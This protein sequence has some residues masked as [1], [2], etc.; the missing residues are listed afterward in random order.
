MKKA[1][2]LYVLLLAMAASF[3]VPRPV[4]AH[5]SLIE[6]VPAED[7]RLAG[8]PA[9]VTLTFS[10]RVEN[11]LFS[12]RVLDRRGKAISQ[13]K[14]TISNNGR[15][16]SL[17]LPDAGAG[18]YT[19]SY[20]VISADG[21][22][23]SGA[24]VYTVGQP[25]PGGGGT[26]PIPD[27]GGNSAR[28]SRDMSV[29]D[30]LAF[31]SRIAYYASLIGLAGWV[32]WRAWR[33]SQPEDEAART[34]DAWS[35]ALKRMF[36]LALIAA[37]GLQ[38]KNYVPQPNADNVLALFFH[39]SVGLSWT[40]SL[41]LALA[42]FPLLHRNRWIDSLW[43]GLLLGAK[44]ASGHAYGLAS[45]RTALALDFVH[46]A[47]AAIW[48][49]GLLHLVAH[50][51]RPAWIAAFLPAFSFAALCS[52]LIL[53][54]SGAFLTLA[55]VPNVAYVLYTQWGTVLLIKIALVV[56]VAAIG[57][58]IRIALKKQASTAFARLV[59][60]DFALMTAV[61]SIV[62]VLTFLNPQPANE[63]L[64]WH[65]MGTKQH[66]SAVIKP[67][68]PGPNT[69][70]VHVWMPEQS[71]APKRVELLL[72]RTSGGD[73]APVEVPLEPL[74]IDDA[75]KSLYAGFTMYSYGAQGAQLSL[76]GKWNVQVRVMDANDDE[77]VYDKEMRIY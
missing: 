47:A 16:L 13:A 65:V 53:A 71:A 55:F 72:T 64:A 74:A 33:R 51:K 21:H 11:K 54:L 42:S 41:A 37:I 20:S 77:T 8:P 63:P 1:F 61:L 27:A 68:A 58:A 76:P 60:V 26:A 48:A 31:A 66:M 70:T 19:V 59:R 5:A 35:L 57:A 50:R 4:S 28:L 39:T 40:V 25:E 12:I 14:A 22:P 2:A 3:A 6:A 9:K 7:S 23:V 75:L 44:T 34:N 10:E 24:Y 18:V 15:E 43:I 62:G 17:D 69:F 30:M 32:L 46:L 49:G 67:N 36:L 73:R 29:A 52:M 56:L 38:L 45:D